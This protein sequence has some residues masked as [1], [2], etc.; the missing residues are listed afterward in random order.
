MNVLGIV[1]REL[2]RS[3]R[4]DVRE[5]ERLL[6]LLGRDADSDAPL[7]DLKA[8]LATRIRDGSLDVPRDELLDHLRETLRDKL[9][10]ANPEYL[11]D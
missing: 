6:A 2:E 7:A 5:R 11:S 3:H 8:E 4:F 1:Q 10:I 9:A